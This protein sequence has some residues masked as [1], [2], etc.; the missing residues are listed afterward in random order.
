MCTYNKMSR[1]RVYSL[2]HRLISMASSTSLFRAVTGSTKPT[3]GVISQAL[4]NVTSEEE[5][6]TTEPK[7]IALPDELFE[8]GTGYCSRENHVSS[9]PREGEGKYVFDITRM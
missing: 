3:M 6:K 9:L 8:I 7:G 5:E 1:H 2:V 4:Q